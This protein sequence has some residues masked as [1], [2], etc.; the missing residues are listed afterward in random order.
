MSDDRRGP[1]VVGALTVF[2]GAVLFLAAG[3]VIPL[4][5]RTF[6]GPRWLVALLAL[7]IFFGG[8]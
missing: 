7:G 3:D 2:T 8:F 5:D 6:G 1:F 4:P